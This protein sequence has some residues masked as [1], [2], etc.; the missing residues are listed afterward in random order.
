MG[1]LEPSGEPTANL[2]GSVGPLRLLT[3]MGGLDLG[4]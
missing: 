4:L 2:S 1:G 3:G